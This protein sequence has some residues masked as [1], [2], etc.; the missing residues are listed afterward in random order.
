VITI[1]RKQELLNQIILA[2]V[3]QNDATRLEDY[4]ANLPASANQIH[5]KL[6]SW[7][8]TYYHATH[9][10]TDAQRI[11]AVILA[12]HPGDPE[13]KSLVQFSDAL[14]RLQHPNNPLAVP[15]SATIAVLKEVAASGTAVA[16]AACPIARRYS[17]AC[18]CRFATKSTAPAAGALNQSIVPDKLMLGSIYPNPAAEL[19]HIPYR[20]PVGEAITSLEVRNSLGQLV[21]QVGLSARTGE[22]AV[23]VS[24][25][26]AGLYNIELVQGGQR[27]AMQRVAITH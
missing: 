15:A 19:I 17:P 13:V 21:Q 22:A 5:A 10:E 27:L 16:R 9:H 1:S 12:R 6:G 24:H 25:W 11:R 4:L 2:T 3:Q 26:S 8:L 14:V 7:L 23:N 20:L 18:P